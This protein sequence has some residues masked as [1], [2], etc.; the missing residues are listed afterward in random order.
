MTSESACR[1]SLIAALEKFPTSQQDE[2]V[3]RNRFLH[4]LTTAPNSA[5]RDNFPAH[6]T[7]S[8]WVIH[9]TLDACL[10]IFH[11]K[12]GIWIQAGGHADGDFNLLEVAKR[13][14]REETGLSV[15]VLLDGAIFDLDIHDIPERANTPRHQHFD[16][17]Y[18]FRAEEESH[19]IPNDEVQA[20][21]WVMFDELEKYTREESIVRMRDRSARLLS[22]DK[23]S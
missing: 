6:L 13:E 18:L 8:A 15:Q 9:A 11:K 14:V 2:E 5:H 4:L 1:K 21:E 20:V 19:L 23:S 12:L 10:L 7:A 3:I 16:V 17:R 22:L